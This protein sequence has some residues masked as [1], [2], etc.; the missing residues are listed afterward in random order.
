VKSGKAVLLNSPDSIEMSNDMRALGAGSD[1]RGPEAMG[2]R[3]QVLSIAVL[4]PNLERRNIVA[5]ILCG[6]RSNAMMPRVT[7]LMNIEDFRSLAKQ[8][9][10]IVFVAV[11]GDPE[12][13]MDTVKA[14]CRNGSGIVV[15]YS[16]ATNDDLL[17]NCIRAGVREFL[18]YPFEPSVVEAALVRV[19]DRGLLAPE[20]KKVVGKSFLFIGAK[21]GSGG[22]TAACNFA[23]SMA[24]DSKKETLLI[25]LDLPLGDASLVLGV[26]GEFST[27]DALNDPERLDSTFLRKLV[28]QHSSG[29]YVLGAPGHFVGS[30]V[31]RDGIDKLIEVASRTFEYVVIDAGSRWD[32]AQIRIFDMVSTIYLVTQVGIAELRNANRLITGCL[33]PY[34]QKLEVVLNRFKDMK[35]GIEFDAIEKALTRQAD[36]RIPNDYEAV[37]EMQTTATP[38]ALKESRIQRSIQKM[39]RMASGI[40]DEQHRKKKKFGLFGFAS[41]V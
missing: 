6:L 16:P 3:A 38:L 27:V 5:G 8:D 32:L 10:R 29:L 40:P 14:V 28:A 24:K 1:A 21:G 34:S 11:D 25:D 18:I 17:I 9:F 30:G 35:F 33:Q 15:G 2:G 4:D 22:T 12:F 23:V 37:M 7:T 19:N 36:W 20:P 31:S 39:A 26:A 13:A 41:G